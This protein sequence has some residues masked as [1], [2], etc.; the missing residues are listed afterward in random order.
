MSFLVKGVLFVAE[1]E[2][3]VAFILEMGEEGSQ[4]DEER[5]EEIVPATNAVKLAHLDQVIELHLIGVGTL[6]G[7]AGDTSNQGISSC[8]GSAED[9]SVVH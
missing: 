7:E 6:W 1:V 5:H 4:D 2:V 8:N 3:I 9:Q